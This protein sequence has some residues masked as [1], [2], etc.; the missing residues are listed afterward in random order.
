M[1]LELVWPYIVENDNPSVQGYLACTQNQTSSLFK[2]KYEQ[3][4]YHLQ[5]IIN[6]HIGVHTK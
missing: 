5:S 1:S 3:I 6:F 4:F 2:L